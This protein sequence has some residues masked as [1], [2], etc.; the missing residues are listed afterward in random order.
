MIFLEYVVKIILPLS[1]TEP[2][3]LKERREIIKE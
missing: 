1:A 3:Q 2:R